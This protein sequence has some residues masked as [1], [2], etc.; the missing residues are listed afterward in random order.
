MKMEIK[1]RETNGD[2]QWNIEWI[3]KFSFGNLPVED[4]RMRITNERWRKTSTE[5]LMEM[6]RTSYG[7]VSTWIF[8]TETIFSLISS[9]PKIPGGL[10][11]FLLH[12]SPYL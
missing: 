10:N 11:V 2:P 5:L 12:S 7:S 9:D 1:V 4:R 6:S 3:E 8:F